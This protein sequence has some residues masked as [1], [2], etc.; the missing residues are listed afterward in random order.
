MDIKG[1]ITVFPKE[2]GK[3]KI[4]IFETSINRK[5]KDGN[6]K[7]GYTLRV[8][9]SEDVLSGDNRN[10]M[11]AGNYYG[12]EVEGFLTTRGYEDKNGNHRTEPVIFVNKGKLTEKGKPVK[13]TERKAKAQSIEIEDDD[14]D[15]LDEAL[16]N[17]AEADAE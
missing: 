13:K 17:P 15:D 5:D 8:V 10:K 11:K 9:F 12:F 7:D 1:K 6:Y 16:E 14:L 4:K 2:V 3:D